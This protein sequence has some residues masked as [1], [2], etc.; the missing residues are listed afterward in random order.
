MIMVEKITPQNALLFK[1]VRL[2]ALQDTPIAF[3]ATYERESTL[4]DDDWI[5]RTLDWGGVKGIGF[6]AMDEASPCG[7]AGS[8]MHQEDEATASL[9]SMWI[10]PAYRRRGVGRLLV[11][12]IETWARSRGAHSLQLM[13]TSVNDSACLFYE[14]L[15]FRRTGRTAPYPND[16]NVIEYEMAKGLLD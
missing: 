12:E 7:I 3:S 2:S 5:Q 11:G 9:I 4:N 8:F 13:I 1:T 14:C 15:G 16:P 6:L 10:A